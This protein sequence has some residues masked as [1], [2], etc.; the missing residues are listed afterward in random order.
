ML[1]CFFKEDNC[2]IYYVEGDVDVLFVKIVV[3]FFRE[4]NIVF[5][6]RWYWF[7]CIVVFL[8]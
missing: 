1:S 2:L 3:E 5:C 4:S 8:Y 7:I 6:G